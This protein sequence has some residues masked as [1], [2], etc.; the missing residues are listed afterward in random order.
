MVQRMPAQLFFVPPMECKEIRQVESI[1]TGAEW[2]Y[3]L[4]FDGYRC[5]GI[6]QHNSAE[7]FSRRGRSFVQ[8]INLNGE[9]QEQRPKAF[10]LDGEVVALD[11]QGRSD[12][13]ALQ[14]AI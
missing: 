11:G 12:F 13:N 3:E 2:Q 10:I 9:L 4:K 7:L 6:K 8:F 1:P 5:I 14:R